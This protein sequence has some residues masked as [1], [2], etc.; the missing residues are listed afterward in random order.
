MDNFQIVSFLLVAALF[1]SML[2]FSFVVA[3]LIFVKLEPLIAGK[4]IRSIFPW[5]YLIIIILSFL[6]FLCFSFTD[7]SVFNNASALAIVIFITALASRQLLMPQINLARDKMQLDDGKS[8]LVFNWLHRLS[9]IINFIQII[10][11]L[12]I[13][14]SLLKL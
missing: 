4:F 10:L 8:R 2:F 11:T 14:L 7:D 12:F 5:Y 3:P 9:V 13:L 1:G 6:A